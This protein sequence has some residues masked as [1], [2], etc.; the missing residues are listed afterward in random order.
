MRSSRIATMSAFDPGAGLPKPGQLRAFATEGRHVEDG[1][2]P[3]HEL[4]NIVRQGHLIDEVSRAAHLGSD[5][6]P[7]RRV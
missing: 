5:V 4:A 6:D 7:E 3:P 1:R 2:G